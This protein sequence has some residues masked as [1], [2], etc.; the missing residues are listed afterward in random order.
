MIKLKRK[1]LKIGLI[2]LGLTILFIIDD[3]LILVLIGELRIWNIAPFTYIVI[4]II[5]IFLNMSLALVVYHV[6][7][8]KPTTGIEGMIGKIGTSLETFYNSGKITINGEIWQAESSTKIYKG[9][10]VEITGISGL[11]LMIKQKK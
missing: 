8:K 7:R 6:L 4:S 5:V 2:F 10:K 1:W 9:D 11:T 3:V